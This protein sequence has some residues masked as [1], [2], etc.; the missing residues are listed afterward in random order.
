[1]KSQRIIDFSVIKKI[2]ASLKAKDCDRLALA[3]ALAAY[4]GFRNSDY[5]R[6][7]WKHLVFPDLA[8]RRSITIVQKKTK[9]KTD[10]PVAK[11]LQDIVSWYVSRNRIKLDAAVVIV[12][13]GKNTGEPVATLPGWTK[14]L[15]AA[16]KKSGIETG[17]PVGTHAFRRA[18]GKS[19]FDNQGGTERALILLSRIFRHSTPA[20]T[21]RY[22]GIEGEQIKQ[23]FDSL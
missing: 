17:G 3:V 4:T 8:P 1:M 5:K 15:N 14:L 19:M 9:K 11:G 13:R 18:F 10:I 12:L 2:I 21:A 22:I 20:V 23:A 6:L 16:I 7:Q